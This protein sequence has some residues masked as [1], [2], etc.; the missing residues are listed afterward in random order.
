MENNSSGGGQNCK[1]CLQT[2]LQAFCILLLVQEK[3]LAELRA[4]LDREGVLR[5]QFGELQLLGDRL[6]L[7]AMQV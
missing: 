2:N 1:L 6:Q 4:S 5:P 7:T 3:R